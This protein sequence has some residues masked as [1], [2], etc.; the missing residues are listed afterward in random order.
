MRRELFGRDWGNYRRKGG[1]AK[2]PVI[3]GGYWG[4]IYLSAALFVLVAYI[5][6][7][8]DTCT[9]TSTWFVGTTECVCFLSNI[10]K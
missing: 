8:T 1:M 3:T 9:G 10:L 4:I 5:V 7:R 6:P 2:Y